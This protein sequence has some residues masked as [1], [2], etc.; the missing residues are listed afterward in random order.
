M[1]HQ[2]SLEQFYAEYPRIEAEFQAA[3]DISIKPRG[4]ELLYDLV[5]DL[6]MPPGATVIDVGCGEGQHTIQLAERFGFA[7]AGFDP[8]P[9]HVELADEALAATRHRALRDRVHFALGTAEALP[10][11]DASVDLVWCR[12]VLVHVT[13]LDQAFAEFGRVVREDG[14]VIVYQVVGTHRLEPRE[15]EW[16][17]RTMG[18]VAASADPRRIEAAIAAG[19]LQIEE[20]IDLSTEWGEKAEEDAGA[21]SRHLLH[22]ARLLRAPERYAGQFGQAAYDISLGDALWHVYGMIGKLS[23]RVYLLARP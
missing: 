12:D 21:A 5:R 2:F 11:D 22:A 19:G 14:R 10:V 20:Q 23:G 18:V 16:L 4:P 17:W 1:R 3:L 15:A 13:A 7:V 9:R 6:G 8:V